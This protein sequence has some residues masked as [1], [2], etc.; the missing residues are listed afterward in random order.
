MTYVF[1]IGYFKSSIKHILLLTFNGLM[2]R[3]YKTLSLFLSQKKT[4]HFFFLVRIFS[5][6]YYNLFID[7][8]KYIQNGLKL[9]FILRFINTELS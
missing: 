8:E 6:I 9:E 3:S 7:S 2:S 4:E 1:L 5:R